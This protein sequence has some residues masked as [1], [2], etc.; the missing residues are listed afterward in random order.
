VLLGFTAIAQEMSVDVSKSEIKWTGKK[1]SGEHWGYINLKSGSFTLENGKIV[2]GMFIIDMT[3][4]VC[5]DLESP[6]W[7]QKLV[8]HLKSDDFFS[9]DKFE[10]ATLKINES[11]EFKNDVAE[12]KGDL[13]I[14]GITKPISFK[15]KKESGKYMAKITVDRTKYDVKYGSGKFF[16]NL[17]DNMIDDDFTLD[18]KLVTK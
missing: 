10:T 15:A 13:T 5:K 7:N 18:V 11:S 8:G 1:V 14:K 16:D 12:V 6:E 3:T 9:V 17:G 2:N 4:I